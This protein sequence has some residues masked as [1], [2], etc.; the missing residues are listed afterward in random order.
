MPLTKKPTDPMQRAIPK[1]PK[2]EDIGPTLDTGA[3]MSKYLKRMEELREN[4]KMRDDEIFK[5]MKLSTFVQLIL[6][7]HEIREQ[8]RTIQ[9]FDH[10]SEVKNGHTTKDVQ[11]VSSEAGDIQK[12]FSEPPHTTRSTLE[13]LVRGV[14]EYDTYSDIPQG[15]R[16]SPM[17]SNKDACDTNHE[18]PYLLLDVRDREDFDACHIITAL[19]YPIAMLSRSINFETPEMLAFRNKPGQIIIVYD[20]DE[21]LAPRAATTLVQRGYA[22]LYLLSGGLKVAW[23]HF[24]EGLIVGEMPSS[25]RQA[26]KLKTRDRSSGVS[27]GIGNRASSASSSKHNCLPGALSSAP[28]FGTRV[29]TPTLY[30]QPGSRDTANGLEDF[31]SEDIVKLTLQLENGMDD[32]RS[33]RSGYSRSTL[34]SARHSA[35][36]TA[37]AGVCRRPFR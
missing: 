9:T 28:S 33:V 21:R 8:S 2:Y 12:D 24:P 27:T 15:D 13:N 1:N 5:R 6:Q 16:K 23:K 30:C 34:S 37:S 32:G 22:N 26:L 17:V 4:F 14:G 3:S 7:I 10:I 19:N 25:V 11:Q 20:E 35:C 18:T 31:L 29:V 36:T